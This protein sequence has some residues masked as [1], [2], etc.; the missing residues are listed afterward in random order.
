MRNEENALRGTHIKIPASPYGRFAGITSKSIFFVSHCYNPISKF[1][2]IPNGKWFKF[3][4]SNHS[5]VEV[6]P[7]SVQDQC[8][9]FVLSYV[10]ESYNSGM[11]TEFEGKQERPRPR[12]KMIFKL[13][14]TFFP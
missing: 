8:N 2:I 10:H 7:K 13:F 14:S 3:P 6:R 1:N 11:V 4:I 9:H 5:E 12:A